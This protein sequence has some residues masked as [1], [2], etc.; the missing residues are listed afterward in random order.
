MVYVGS[1]DKNLYC[2]SLGTGG[3]SSNEIPIPDPASLIPDHRLELQD[4]D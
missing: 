4:E 3:V 2:F 1:L